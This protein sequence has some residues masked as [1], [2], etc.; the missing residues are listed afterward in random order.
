[1]ITVQPRQGPIP[2]DL[3]ALKDVKGLDGMKKGQM[4]R[5][6]VMWMTDGRYAVM[7]TMKNIGTEEKPKYTHDFFY[8]LYPNIQAVH[9]SFN[10]QT[11]I[12]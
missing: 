2:H 9:D 1:M 6:Y 12:K 11:S 10:E 3:I 8:Q 7:G 4:K 5:C